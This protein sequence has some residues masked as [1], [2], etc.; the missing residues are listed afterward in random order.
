MK[1]RVLVLTEQARTSFVAQLRK[2]GLADREENILV[3]SRFD[4]P[5]MR[6][7][8][9]VE[10]IA[11]D[12]V[13]FGA[14]V[15]MVDT[16]SAFAGLSGDMENNAGDAQQALEPLQRAAATQHLAV[17]LTRHERKSGG[18]VGDSARGSTATGG[19]VDII[20]ALRRVKGLRPTVRKLEALS[21]FD[22]TPGE[23]LIEWTE[24]GYVVVDPEQGKRE[25]AAARSAEHRQQVLDALRPDRA[26]ALTV[27]ELA[28]ATGLCRTKVQTV[29]KALVDEGVA[30]RYQADEPKRPFRYHRTDPTCH[31]DVSERATTARDS[32]TA[33]A[34][35]HA[36]T[37]D[38][39]GGTP[40]S[41]HHHVSRV[42]VPVGED[43]TTARH[44]VRRPPVRNGHDVEHSEICEC[45]GCLPPADTLTRER[46]HGGRH[47]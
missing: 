41:P 32:T 43:S 14:H 21:R 25:Q 17:L 39:G 38:V 45:D 1:R 16:F 42:A 5:P 11:A 7:P 33:D 35:G 12:A 40:Q 24:A 36:A 27:Q 37:R 26:G 15:L 8:A 4:L 2:A 29:A 47:A 20:L 19:G 18:D 10:A 3:V 44:H 23:L 13:R 46:L 31:D 9:L 28:D 22:E 6:W 34:N 30:R